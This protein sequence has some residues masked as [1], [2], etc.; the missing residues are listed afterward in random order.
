MPEAKKC[1][2]EAPVAIVVTRSKRVDEFKTVL[3]RPPKS[4]PAGREI[5]GVPLRKLESILGPTKF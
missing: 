2:T 4:C 5:F 1:L 3:G